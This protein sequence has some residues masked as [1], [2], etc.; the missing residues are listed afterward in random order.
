MVASTEPFPAVPPALKVAVACALELSA[1][2]CACGTE[3]STALPNVTGR[4]TRTS[5]L[6]ARAD[7]EPLLSFLRSAVTV[8]LLLIWREVGLDVFVNFA[9]VEMSVAPV[10]RLVMV[11]EGVL[12]P[13]QL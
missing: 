4:P 7:A 2:G 10:L 5:R 6:P 12:G 13:H 8:E 1:S 3:P 11:P 9:N